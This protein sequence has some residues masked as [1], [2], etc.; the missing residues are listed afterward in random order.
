MPLR[1]LG[2]SEG[3]LWRRRRIAQRAAPPTRGT[4]LPPHRSIKVSGGKAPTRNRASWSCSPCCWR[5]QLP[6]GARPRYSLGGRGVLHRYLLFRTCYRS[7]LNLFSAVVLY[8]ASSY[9]EVQFLELPTTFHIRYQCYHARRPNKPT[10]TAEGGAYGMPGGRG[11]PGGIPGGMPG[12]PR[13]GK[14][15]KAGGMPG[16]PE[17]IP[18]GI[19]GMARG[20]SAPGGMPGGR[21]R[22]RPN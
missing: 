5:A 9:F 12:G 14:P 16:I 4:A 19:P 11:I 13:G 20:G 22:P 1:L 8:S 2:A 3:R 6:W 18:G 10:T 7:R 17:G 15:G 21:G